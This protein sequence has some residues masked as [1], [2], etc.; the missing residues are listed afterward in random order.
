MNYSYFAQNK[1][2][3]KT[4]F[5]RFFIKLYF[6]GL[7]IIFLMFFDF[8]ITF[9]ILTA[10]LFISIII[11]SF[12]G[13]KDLAV[14]RF[15]SNLDNDY[16]NNF[17]KKT[18]LMSLLA[19]FTTFVIIQ[20]ISYFLVIPKAG[21]LI[22]GFLVLGIGNNLASIILYFKQNQHH[23]YGT[24]FEYLLLSTIFNLLL[25]SLFGLTFSI[26]IYL[27][28]AVGIFLV[29]PWI[30]HNLTVVLIT[31]IFYLILFI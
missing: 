7:M 20:V 28:L 26:S 6:S 5:I 13:H 9:Y 29:V 14:I 19:F 17:A 8:D 30:D 2:G 22:L 18:V 3:M 24:T 1:V 23:I 16:Y 31:S 27:S 21:A 10:L 25:F 11:N 12:I 4:E 15:F